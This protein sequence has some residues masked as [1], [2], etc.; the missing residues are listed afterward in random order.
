M[1]DLRVAPS[2][3]LNHYMQSMDNEH[4]SEQQGFERCLALMHLWSSI[5]ASGRESADLRAMLYQDLCTHGVT[6]Y[7]KTLAGFCYELIR[8]DKLALLVKADEQACLALFERTN[9]AMIDLLSRNVVNFNDSFI[10]ML[11]GQPL[12]K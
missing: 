10:V 5:L 4:I 11:P 6:L 2:D 12:V 1:C 3:L 8:A 9:K 7:K